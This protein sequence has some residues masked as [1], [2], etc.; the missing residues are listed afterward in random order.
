MH[1]TLGWSRPNGRPSLNCIIN[2]FLK[3][4]IY[5]CV[6]CL[7]AIYLLKNKKLREENLKTFV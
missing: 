2:L 3:S 6:Y 1:Q 5:I 4:Y 7:L